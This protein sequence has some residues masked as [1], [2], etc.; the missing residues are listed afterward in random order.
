MTTVIGWPRMMTPEM[1]EEYV[2]GQTIL[3][4]LKEEGLLVPRIQQKRL[5]RYDRRELDAALDAWEGFDSE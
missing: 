4:A 3:A 2:G 1:A 5:T